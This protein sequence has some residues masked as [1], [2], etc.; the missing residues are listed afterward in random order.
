MSSILS[1]PT[2]Q[3]TLSSGRDASQGVHC[4][5]RKFEG[6]DHRPPVRLVVFDCDETLTLSTF[7]PK[8]REFERVIGW[9]SWPEYISM[10]NFGTP[11][12]EGSRDFEEP[13]APDGRLGRLQKL[14]QALVRAPDKSARSLAILTRNSRGAVAC[15]NLLMMANLADHFSVI[16]SMAASPGMPN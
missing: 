3:R 12:V 4:F 9:S 1:P 13:Y 2:F 14:F 7:M 8:D 6:E 16:W 5:E 10:M 15:L 11:F